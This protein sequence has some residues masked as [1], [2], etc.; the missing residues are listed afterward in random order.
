VELIMPTAPLLKVRGYLLHLTHYDPV[1]VLEKKHERHFDLPVALRLV[2]A[3]A[4]GGF[5]TLL[6]GVSDGVIF[7]SHPELRRR[8]S[9]PI[10]QL[11]TLCAHARERGLDVV[12]KLNF[13]KSEVN[14][15]DHWSRAPGEAWHTHFDDDAYFQRGFDVIDELIAACQPARYFH[16]GMDEDHER[17]HAQYIA[18]IRRL[19]AGLKQRKLRTVCWTDSA[20]DYA[21]GQV[22]REKC[23]AAERVLPHDTVRLLWNYWAVPK[24]EL[25]T[26]GKQGFE[27]WGAPGR[28]PEQIN[29]FRKA[30]LAAGGTGMVMTRWIACQKKN[31]A[32][33]LDMIR[34][35][36]PLYSA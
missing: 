35:L 1:W 10:E 3:L 14:C 8:Y 33:L 11:A 7:G 16:V 34:T 18:A 25:Q 6:V 29:A 15:H 5:N 13:S 28:K 21:S 20:L 26:I 31:Q 36:G 32:E 23:A 19:R 12:P 30:L 2:D 17:A 22:Y 24:R 9:V 27:L 4:E